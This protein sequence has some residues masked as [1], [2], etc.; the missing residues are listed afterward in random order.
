M[1]VSLEQD[2]SREDIEVLIRYASMNQTV[3]KLERLITS[4]DRGVE[5]SRDEERLWVNAGDIFYIESV[6]KRTFVYGESEVYRC[7]KR[8]YQLEEEL[9]GA[10]FVKASKSCILNV[11]VLESIRPLRNSRMEATLSNGEKVDVTRKYVSAI[12]EKVLGR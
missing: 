10:G 1:K 6:D 8:L 11:N 2:L 4:V 7:D 9:A 5:C 12:K 3:R